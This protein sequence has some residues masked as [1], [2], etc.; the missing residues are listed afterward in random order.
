MTNSRQSSLSRV[1]DSAM[2]R[3]VL[4][5]ARLTA[6]LALFGAVL[7]AA[8]CAAA[9]A[10]PEVRRIEASDIG[11]ITEDVRGGTAYVVGKTD[12]ADRLGRDIVRSFERSH[13]AKLRAPVELGALTS[14]G[15]AATQWAAVIP[16][17]RTAN[18]VAARSDAG[19]VM[20]V[21]RVGPFGDEMTEHGYAR[22]LAGSLT[23][24]ARPKREHNFSLPAWDE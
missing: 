21:I 11:T 12:D 9:R 6:A 7:V 10:L 24:K 15:P 16:D 14:T 3:G 1:K 19:V 4:S 5:I 18:I 8:G 17:G 20:I 2:G 13:W 22:E 23:E